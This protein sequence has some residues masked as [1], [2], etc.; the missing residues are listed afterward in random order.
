M[1]SFWKYYMTGF[2]LLFFVL[3]AHAQSEVDR[4]YL[5]GIMPGDTIEDFIVQDSISYY[6]GDDLF[7]Y[8]N[9]GADIFLEYGFIGAAS[10]KYTSGNGSLLHPEIYLMEDPE[11]AFGIYSVHSAGKGRSI[12][13]IGSSAYIYDSHID[14]W[15]GRVFIRISLITDESGSDNSALLREVAKN[16][17]QNVGEESDPPEML[18][19]LSRSGLK[20]E[21]PG[22]FEGIIALNNIYTFGH[23]AIYGFSEGISAIAGDNRLFVFGYENEKMR[24]E[25]YQNMRGKIRHLKKYSEYTDHG[26]GFSVVD[27]DGLRLNFMPFGRYFAI[28]TGSDW[29]ASQDIFEQVNKALSA[30]Q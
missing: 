12:N 24:Y 2:C 6:F 26:D 19:E 18:K 23:G 8:I 1:I 9:G 29:L 20:T 15:Q 7:Y 25:W 13:N 17:A 16:M 4:E 27:R 30:D 3:S 21:Q 28:V 10:S 5:A 11:A 22:Y 14:L